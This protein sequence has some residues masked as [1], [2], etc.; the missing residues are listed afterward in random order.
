MDLLAGFRYLP[1]LMNAIVLAVDDE[2]L[3]LLP[4]PSFHVSHT[5]ISLPVQVPEI[6]VIFKFWLIEIR[7]QMS[8]VRTLHLV[9]NFPGLGWR[10][11]TI[12]IDIAVLQR[13]KSPLQ[14]LNLA[15]Y[16]VMSKVLSGA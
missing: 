15:L 8:C 7:H 6:S 10:C 9:Q 14:T 5:L 13:R 11:I 12:R 1:P 16:R 4:C 2:W 3:F